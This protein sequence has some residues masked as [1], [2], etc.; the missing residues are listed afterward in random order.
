MLSPETPLRLMVGRTTQN[1]ASSTISPA[2]RFVILAVTS[3]RVYVGVSCTAVTR[4]MATSLYLIRVLPASMPSAAVKTMVI[5][6]PS[7]RNR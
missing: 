7:L 3:T 5:V 6:G 2:A 1:F 4:P